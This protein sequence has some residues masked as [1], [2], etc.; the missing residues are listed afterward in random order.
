MALQERSMEVIGTLGESAFRTL[1]SLRK[2]LLLVCSLLTGFLIWNIPPSASLDIN[3]VHFLATLTVGV[4]LWIGD[5]FDDYVVGLMLLMSWVVLEIVPSKLALAGFSQNSWFFV[6]SALGLGA[7]VNKSGLLHRLAIRM[8]RRIPL[9]SH[10]IHSF[11]LF[12]SGLLITP[13]LPTGKA[14]AVIAL[15]VSQAIAKATGFADRSNGSA[16]LS[17]AALI[18]FSHMSFMFLTGGEFCLIGW[19]LLPLEA[20]VEFGWMAWFLAA[21]PAGIMIFLFVLMAIHFLFPLKAEDR[22]VHLK[23]ATQPE[24]ENPGPLR[25]AEWIGVIVLALTLLGWLTKPLH[26]VDETWV[27]LGG[28]L[29]FLMTGAL[30]KKTFRNNMDWGLVVFFGI[31]N[32][33]AVISKHL[34]IDRWVSGLVS[35]ILAGVS[36]N[37]IEF[38]I[39]VIVIVCLTRFFLRKSASIALL[40]LILVPV[41]HDIGIHPGVIL[42]T[43][44]A[45]S[46]CFFLPYQDGPYQIAYSSTDGQ[47]FSHRQ[48]RKILAARFLATLLAVAISI[49]YWRVLGLI[50]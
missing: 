1:P 35:P 33:M 27:A 46:E 18:G 15:P 20:K 22:V 16:A 17:L 31:I 21:L 32:S 9:T 11:V 42:L 25:Q 48:A 45:A 23:G 34:K 30:D 44:L 39:A 6:V 47:A 26:G 2:P 38:L 7:A 5:V 13:L 10:K 50:Q 24:L 40:T 19:N 4:V 43:I 28:L 3:G 36:T 29:V 8:L 49:P 14:R 41:G 12:A 37:R